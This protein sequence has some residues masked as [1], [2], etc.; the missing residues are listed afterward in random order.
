MASGAAATSA[1]NSSGAACVGAKDGYTS[2]GAAVGVASLSV[3]VA[4]SLEGAGSIRSK[5]DAEAGSEDAAWLSDA[6]S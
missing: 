6:R 4:L 3:A 2:A 5:D 1:A